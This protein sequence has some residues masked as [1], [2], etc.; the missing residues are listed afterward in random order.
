MAVGVFDVDREGGAVFAAACAGDGDA[1]RAQLGHEAVGIGGFHQQA[2]VVEPACVAV[3]RWLVV[4]ALHQVDQLPAGAHV[5]VDV[6]EP[7]RRRECLFRGGA[8]G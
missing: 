2:D 5:Q 4:G 1:A 7:E 3:G 6:I 8:F